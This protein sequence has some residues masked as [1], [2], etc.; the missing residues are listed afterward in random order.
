[1]VW[2][3]IMQEK[4]GEKSV[5]NVW[6]IKRKEIYGVF[7][8]FVFGIVGF[9]VVDSV[10]ILSYVLVLSHFLCHRTGR[11]PFPLSR[12]KSSISDVRERSDRVASTG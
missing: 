6:A 5:S 1:M 3:K 12:S 2:K 8:V 11:H 10:Q 7:V 9:D 4:G